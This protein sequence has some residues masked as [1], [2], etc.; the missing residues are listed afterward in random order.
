MP[1]NPKRNEAKAQPSPPEPTMRQERTVQATIFEVSAGHE[2]GCELKAISQWLD[3]QRALVS[4]VA[5]DCV[6]TGCARPDAVACRPRQ[7]CAVRCSSQKL[8]TCPEIIE[9]SFERV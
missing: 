8:R 2:I 5:G 9:S 4:L 6:A 7:C 3:Q 1:L